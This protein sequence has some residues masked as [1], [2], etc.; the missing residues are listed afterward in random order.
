M[1][2]YQ[3]SLQ[4]DPSAHPFVRFVWAEMAKQQVSQED[5]TERSGVPSSTMRHWRRADRKPALRDLEAVL[6]VLGY[7]LTIEESA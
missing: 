2:L 4:A 6:A 1:R 5:I 7:V 3:R